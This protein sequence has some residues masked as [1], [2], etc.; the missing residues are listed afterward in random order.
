MV[1]EKQSSMFREYHLNG[2][3]KP[4]GWYR[5]YILNGFCDTYQMVFRRSALCNSPSLTPRSLHRFQQTVNR[6]FLL[7]PRVAILPLLCA[8]IRARSTLLSFSNV[9]WSVGLIYVRDFLQ[10]TFQVAASLLD[11]FCATAERLMYIQTKQT[12]QNR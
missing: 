1:F 4:S 7:P 6:I 11:K 8:V 2:F 5:Q 3:G 12:D 9:H 10:R